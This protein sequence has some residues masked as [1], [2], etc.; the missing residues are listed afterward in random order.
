MSACLPGPPVLGTGQTS[1]QTAPATACGDCLLFRSLAVNNDGFLMPEP[2]VVEI[3]D[4]NQPVFP[5]FFPLR[6]SCLLVPQPE[7]A[8][9]A[10]YDMWIITEADVFHLMAAAGTT[11]RVDIPVFLD[12][13]P[14]GF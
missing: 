10:F 7:M 13:L 9:D 4:D 8:E 3:F 11:E 5:C 2:A 14:P 12:E 1:G 6:E